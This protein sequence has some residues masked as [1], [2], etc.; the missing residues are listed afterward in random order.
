MV[1]TDYLEKYY[2]VRQIPNNIRVGICVLVYG[3]GAGI[4]DG[5]GCPCVF[6]LLNGLNV[7]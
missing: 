1:Y 6:T 4:L 3:G 7:A 2:R 5:R